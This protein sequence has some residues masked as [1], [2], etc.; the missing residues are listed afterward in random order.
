MCDH[1]L[2]LLAASIQKDAT[3]LYY[4]IIKLIAALSQATAQVTPAPPA[5]RSSVTGETTQWA[6]PQRVSAASRSP[7]RTGTGS[8]DR[9]LHYLNTQFPLA[10]ATHRAH[11]SG[12]PRPV[13]DSTG[14]TSFTGKKG[15]RGHVTYKKS[16][17]TSFRW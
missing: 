12:A 15:A 3:V 11:Q 4:Y 6:A 10:L 14:E 9:V 8:P 1:N 2:F 16:K 13:N 7:A 5:C 17:L